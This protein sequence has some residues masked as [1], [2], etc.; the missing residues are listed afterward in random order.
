MTK[1]T[2]G[3]FGLTGC[4]GDQLVLL[5]CEDELLTLLDLVDTRDFLMASSSNDEYCPL[6]VAL[7]EGAVVTDRDETRLRR[8]RDRAGLLVALGTC[9]VWGGIAAMDR[10][11]DRAALVREIYG[12]AGQTPRDRTALAL[13]EVVRV[14]ASITGCPVEATQLL[15]AL[16]HLLQGNPPV[17]PGYPVCTEC[18]IR[19]CGCLLLEDG[20]ACC[21]II[22][23]AGCGARCPA[24]GVPCIGCRGP[25]ADP[26]TESAFRRYRD[27]GLAE[28][29]AVA[30]LRTFA[31]ETAGEGGV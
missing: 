5:D 4:A 30:V 31:P 9:A 17:F 12:T 10:R 11:F 26:N 14:D 24:L 29:D 3:V 21:G 18:R 15:E 13:H 1:P 7:V 19:E 25:A 2:L 20:R 8:I 16:A 6:D 27:L 28:R 23:A 22:T